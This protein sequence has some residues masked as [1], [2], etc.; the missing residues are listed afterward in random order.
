MSDFLV[1]L[2]NY[3]LFE[4]MNDFPPVF[5]LYII[6]T[7]KQY[8][9]Q[10]FVFYQDNFS[11]HKLLVCLCVCQTPTNLTPRSKQRRRFINYIFIFFCFT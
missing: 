2:T 7:Y 4:I 11:C 5:L 10:L 1:F 6:Y 9:F 8:F 3:E